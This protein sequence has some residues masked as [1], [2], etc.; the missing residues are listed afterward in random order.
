MRRAPFSGAFFS[1]E[2]K[3]QRGCSGGI[4]NDAHIVW[5]ALWPSFGEEWD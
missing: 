1:R 5:D 4:V 3:V 2:K